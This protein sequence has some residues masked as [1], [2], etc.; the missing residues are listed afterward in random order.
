MSRALSS[1]MTSRPQALLQT[2]QELAD[3]QLQQ[4]TDTATL[5][6]CYETGNNNNKKKKRLVFST[7]WHQ[8]HILFLY[9]VDMNKFCNRGR[10]FLTSVY[11]LSGSSI[12]SI[13]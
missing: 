4:D 3:Y 12:E 10:L 5:Q 13:A 2:Y 1:G 9:I 6:P 11:S 8:F 7:F